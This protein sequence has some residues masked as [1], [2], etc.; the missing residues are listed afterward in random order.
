MGNQARLCYRFDHIASAT[1]PTKILRLLL[2]SRSHAGGS[3]AHLNRTCF[4]PFWIDL[5][6]NL[7]D[8]FLSPNRPMRQLDSGQVPGM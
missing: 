4:L 1:S 7:G 5:G 6:P 3:R 2:L 8:F